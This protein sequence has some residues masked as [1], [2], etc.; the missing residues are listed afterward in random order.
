MLRGQLGNGS[1]PI[2]FVNEG[3]RAPDRKRPI[4]ALRKHGIADGATRIPLHRP[5]ESPRYQLRDAIW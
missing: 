3:V 1:S 2:V 4:R 5:F